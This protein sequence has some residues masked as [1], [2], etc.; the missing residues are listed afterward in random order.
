[1]RKPVAAM[2]SPL[3]PEMVV[4]PMASIETLHERV[5]ELERTAGELENRVLAYEEVFFGNPVPALVYAADS[6]AILE[7]NKS[8]LSL[9]GYE[10]EHIRSLNLLDLFAKKS[11]KGPELEAE[12]RKPAN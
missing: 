4:G 10:Q 1:M 6:L 12:L 2:R 3:S 7:A 9:Y 8:A 5:A 11:Q